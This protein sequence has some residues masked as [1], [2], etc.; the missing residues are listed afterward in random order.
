MGEFQDDALTLEL[1]LDA[2]PADDPTDD[3][4]PHVYEQALDRLACALG[5]KSVLPPAFQFIPSM[6]ASYDWR[7]RHAGLMAIAAIG[8]GTSKVMQNEL[9]KV[10]DLVTPMF[11]DTHPRVR[12]AACQC[13]GQL[14]TDLEVYFLFSAV[15]PC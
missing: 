8:E 13:V 9:G 6:L 4:Y 10:V 15:A 5:G 14:C 2:D 12:Y 11:R 1:W 3:T 7:I